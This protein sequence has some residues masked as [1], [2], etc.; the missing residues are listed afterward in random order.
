V[1]L[2]LTFLTACAFE[3]DVEPGTFSG[4]VLQRTAL[5]PN[6]IARAYG[7]AVVRPRRTVLYSSTGLVFSKRHSVCPWSGG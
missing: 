6:L 2:L 5:K 7:T 1:L 3:D 4:P